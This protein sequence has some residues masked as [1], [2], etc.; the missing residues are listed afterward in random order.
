MEAEIWYGT[1]VV[2]V[3]VALRVFVSPTT[4]IKIWHHGTRFVTVIAE[5]VCKTGRRIYREAR[6][7]GH[8]NFD[9][10]VFDFLI[11]IC[12]ASYFF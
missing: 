3:L 4:T 9:I 10:V 2:D 8:R 12:S 6:V 7:S 1:R 5:V 11:N